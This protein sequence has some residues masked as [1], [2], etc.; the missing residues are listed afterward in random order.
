M[1][2][3]ANALTLLTTYEG[4]LPIGAPTS[5]VISNFICYQLDSDLIDFCGENHLTFTR[6]ADDLTFS[7]DT[8]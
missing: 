4:K 8:Q 7:S 1:I 2:R 3:L 5:P 6:Y